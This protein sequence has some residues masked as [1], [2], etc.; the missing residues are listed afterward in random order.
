M[1][2]VFDKSNMEYTQSRYDERY[3]NKPNHFCLN[4][5]WTLQQ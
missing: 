3:L 1:N 2:F 5:I 4:I